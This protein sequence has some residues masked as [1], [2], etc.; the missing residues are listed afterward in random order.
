MA[1]SQ[2]LVLIGGI[3]HVPILTGLLWSVDKRMG[4]TYKAE[5]AAKEEAAAKAKAQADAAA[6]AAAAEKAKADARAKAE[7]KLKA[8][9]EAKAKQDSN[10]D[11]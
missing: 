1:Y 10:E 11:G 6:A 8:E 2:T 9:A 3:A 5:Q 7:A 4:K